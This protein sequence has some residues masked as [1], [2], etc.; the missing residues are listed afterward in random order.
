MWCWRIIGV[1]PPH[2]ST[3]FFRILGQVI[4]QRTG[5]IFPRNFHPIQWHKQDCVYSQTGSPKRLIQRC[6]L[7]KNVCDNKDKKYEP[8]Q[9]L[10]TV[11]GDRINYPR[12]C[13]T[14][15]QIYSPSNSFSEVSSR[16]QIPYLWF[17]ILKKSTSTCHWQDKD[18]SYS[19]WQIFQKMWL[20][21]ARSARKSPMTVLFMWRYRKEFMVWL[22]QGS[23]H[24]SFWK[25]CCTSIETTK[26][27]K[28]LAYGCMTLPQ[29]LFLW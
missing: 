15:H 2:S 23:L 29:Y 10:L 7:W 13:G 20:S 27:Y 1:S 9:K 25:N 12:D 17:W 24:R 16:P 14:P 4:W 19:K 5:K 8:N 6:C 18:T 3:T 22:I 26:T 28:L 11:I 21:I